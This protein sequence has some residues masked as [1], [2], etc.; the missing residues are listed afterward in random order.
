MLKSLF[1]LI[2]NPHSGYIK[3]IIIITVFFFDLVWPFHV[4]EIIF[5]FVN[6]SISLLLL[7]TKGIYINVF[8]TIFLNKYRNVV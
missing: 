1:L 5:K 7:H 6:S 2:L 8:P 3:Y 4:I